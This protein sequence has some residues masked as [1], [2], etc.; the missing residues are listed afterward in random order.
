MSVNRW[1][2]GLAL[3]CLALVMP[4]SQAMAY[5]PPASSRPL[6]NGVDFSAATP[7]NEDY[8][9]Q[10]GA[11][12]RGIAGV[13]QK[14]HFKGHNLR[15]PNRPESKQ[16]YLCSRD[17]SNVKALLKLKDGGILFDSKM[18]LD[19]D[20][21]WAAWNNLPG[22]TDLKETSYKWPGVANSSSQAAQ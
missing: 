6:M 16:F 4:G 15:L 20:G 5:D 3:Q 10:F 9:L 13:G 12:D 18:A 7:L 8:R 2:G 14:D 17:P 1:F 22:A 11:C 21:S 19:V